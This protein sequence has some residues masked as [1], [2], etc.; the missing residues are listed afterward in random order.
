M[1]FLAKRKAEDDAPP[2]KKVKL[3]NGDST[4]AGDDPDASTSVFVGKLSWN[5]DSD[6]LRSEFEECGEVIDARVQ[7]DRNTGKSR[8]FGYVDFATAK[9]VEK[10][11]AL[12]GKEIDGRPI[13]VDRS[14]RSGAQ[15][16]DKQ[17]ADR[18][19][20]VSGDSTSEASNVLFVGNL[21]WNS[22]ED[23]LWN[24]FAEY[25][26]VKSV[27]VPTDRESGRPKGFGYVE[28]TEL[29]SAKKAFEG[30]NGSEIDGRR[31]RL[32]YSTPRDGNGGGGGGRGGSWGDRGGRSGGFGDRGGRGGGFGDRGGG[33]GDRG[34]RGGGFGDRSGR[35]GGWGDRGGRGGRGGGR[36]GSFRGGDRGGRGGRGGGRGGRGGGAR[37]GGIAQFEGQK[38]TFD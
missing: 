17:R 25:G 3:A 24:V 20:K 35:G 37:T 5:V 22:T 36:G 26:D 16:D 15:G 1:K 38:V 14:Q 11:L 19:A 7:M 6:W 31:I 9:A 34:G 2:A 23:S 10:A 8:G 12:D 28:F 30:T 18:R 27:R 33:F 13:R 4:P 29:D 21:S 32:D